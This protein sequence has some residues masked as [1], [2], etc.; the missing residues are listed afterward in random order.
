MYYLALVFI[1]M[2]PVCVI[3]TSFSVNVYIVLIKPLSLDCVHPETLNEEGT[4]I[5]MPSATTFHELRRR[6]A[7]TLTSPAYS[8]GDLVFP[9]C[10]GRG[11][12]FGASVNIS[13]PFS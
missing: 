7:P 10:V 12:I 9:V 13:R 3:F 2:Y 8:C 6:I 5:F 11:L 1:H 4:C